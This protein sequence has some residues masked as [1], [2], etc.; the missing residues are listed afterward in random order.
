[1][2]TRQLQVKRKTRKVRRSKTNVL[3]LCNTTNLLLLMMTT[4]MM[5]MA[6]CATM[7]SA[8]QMSET[9]LILRPIVG[10][11][12]IRLEADSRPQCHPRAA[13]ND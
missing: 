7:S 5:K 11:R 10:C 8:V 9:D 6:V 3:P 13:D 4:T 12:T 1:V 2:V